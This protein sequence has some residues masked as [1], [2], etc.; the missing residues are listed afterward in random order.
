METNVSEAVLPP[1][2]GSKCVVKEMYTLHCWLPDRFLAYDSRQWNCLPYLHCVCVCNSVVQRWAAGWLIGG[3]SSGWGWEFISS[4]PRPNRF[5]NPPSL[6]SSVFQGA[7]SLGVKRPG[8]EA[9]HSPPSSAEVKNAWSYTSTP[10]IPL[11]SS[12]AKRHRR[13]FPSRSTLITL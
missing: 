4:L 13:Q 2:S 8:Y 5:W 9:D 12:N 1:S 11:F 7:L 3:S 10:P 6:L